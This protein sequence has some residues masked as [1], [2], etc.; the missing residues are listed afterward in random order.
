M[1]INLTS[2]RVKSFIPHQHTQFLGINAILYFAAPVGDF[3][4]LASLFGRNYWRW[5]GS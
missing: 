2:I 3:S 1:V 4:G 5:V